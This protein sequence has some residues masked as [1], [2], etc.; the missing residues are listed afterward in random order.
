M[1]TVVRAPHPRG[2]D[3][4]GTDDA[5]GL[6]ARKKRRTRRILERTALAL[7]TERGFDE[8]TEELEVARRWWQEHEHR[9]RLLLMHLLD[10]HDPY[11]FRKP[12]RGLRSEQ[13]LE[14]NLQW[15]GELEQS[16]AET[17]QGLPPRPETPKSRSVAS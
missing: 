15:L 1:A 4:E 9:P 16:M 13:L 17:F 2:D 12:S 8:V 7:F 14:Q 11:G 6:R 3:R 5:L 10:L